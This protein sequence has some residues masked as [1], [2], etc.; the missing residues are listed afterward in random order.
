MMQIRTNYLKLMDTKS[1]YGL[2]NSAIT[3]LF[4]YQRHV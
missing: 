4:I 3:Q 1:L 2:R